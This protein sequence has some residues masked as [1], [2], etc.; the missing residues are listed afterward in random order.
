MCRHELS[1]TE[2]RCPFGFLSCG[3]TKSCI[4]NQCLSLVLSREK[5]K[6]LIKKAFEVDIDNSLEEKEPVALKKKRQAVP[7]DFVVNMEDGDFDDDEE[8]DDNDDEYLVCPPGSTF[9]L[10]TMRCVPGCA[11]GEFLESDRLEMGP[12]FEIEELLDELEQEAEEEDDDDGEYI[13]CPTGTVLCLSTMRCMVNCGAGVSDDLQDDFLDDIFDVAVQTKCPAGQVFC[14][15]VMACV[16]NCG[17]FE[18]QESESGVISPTTCPD[19]TVWCMASEK[20]V[21]ASE[22]C[23]ESGAKLC[24]LGTVWCGDMCQATCENTDTCPPHDQVPGVGHSTCQVPQHCPDGYSC[25]VA[26][27]KFR[28]CVSTANNVT[29]ISPMLD[30]VCTTAPDDLA[31]LA[32]GQCDIDPGVCGP[33]GVCCDGLCHGLPSLNVTLSIDCPVGR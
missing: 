15:Q 10:Q 22:P 1:E 9:C 8:E 7:N 19:G 3:D 33:G 16:S 6:S 11:S 26:S 17:F 20:C 30:S 31:E 29:K 13:S 21:S 24:P 28:Q 27:D 32:G 14:M 2:P 25:C 5:E 12:E 18:D 4:Q 23:G